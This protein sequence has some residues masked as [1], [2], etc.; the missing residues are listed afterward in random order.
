MAALRRKYARRSRRILQEIQLASRPP[1]HR[2]SDVVDTSVLSC[3][4][5]RLSSLADVWDM[6]IDFEPREARL[7]KS[8]HFEELFQKTMGAPGK[9][10][11]RSLPNVENRS[12][13]RRWM[14]FVEDVSDSRELGDTDWSDP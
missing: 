3:P 2:Q 13:A 10:N 8:D 5:I 9:E 1:Q 7:Y 12:T 14:R 6:E 4:P 11:L